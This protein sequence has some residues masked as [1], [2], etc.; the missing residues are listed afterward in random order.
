M[1]ADCLTEENG[2]Q[3]FFCQSGVGSRTSTLV[4]HFVYI[5]GLG[6]ATG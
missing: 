2:V 4:N 6:R 5:Y 1:D 3:R